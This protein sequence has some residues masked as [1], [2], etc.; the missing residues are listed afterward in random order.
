VAGLR[1]G[2]ELLATLLGLPAAQMNQ[3]FARIVADQT[4]VWHSAPYLRNKSFLIGA[5]NYVLP[6]Y[7]IGHL[8]ITNYLRIHGPPIQ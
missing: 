6:S 4:A 3:G 7:S 1:T 2:K 5:V 8:L